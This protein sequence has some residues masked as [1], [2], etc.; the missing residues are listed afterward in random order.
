MDFLGSSAVEPKMGDVIIDCV[1]HGVSAALL[2]FGK[3]RSEPGQSLL[4]GKHGTAVG[5]GVVIGFGENL[6]LVL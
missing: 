4:V 1:L 2:Y 6:G 3:L 5:F